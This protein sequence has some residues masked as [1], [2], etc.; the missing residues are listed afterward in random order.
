[1]SRISCVIPDANAST[2]PLVLGTIAML[3][4]IEPSSAFKVETSGFGFPIVAGDVEDQLRDSGRKRIDLSIGAGHD[5]HVVGDRAIQCV[6]GRDQ[7][8]RLSDRSWRCRGS[9][10]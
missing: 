8:F 2:F 4:V 10:A 7:R 3:L 6:Q 5:C 1:M 9:V